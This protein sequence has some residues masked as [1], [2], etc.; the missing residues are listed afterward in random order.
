MCNLPIWSTHWVHSQQPRFE[1]D[2]SVHRSCYSWSAIAWIEEMHDITVALEWWFTSLKIQYV[3]SMHQKVWNGALWRYANSMCRG[4]RFAP[5]RW[6][7][8]Y[9]L[10]VQ[11]CRFVHNARKII[12]FSR[13]SDISTYHHVLCSSDSTKAHGRYIESRSLIFFS[14][15]CPRKA[16]PIIIHLL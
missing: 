14:R 4:R 12:C 11:H 10:Y 9:D 13:H 7:L 5:K 2:N 3:I 16:W 6:T 8:L 15:I 1:V